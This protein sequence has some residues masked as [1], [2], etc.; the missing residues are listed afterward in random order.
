MA[1][2]LGGMPVKQQDATICASTAKLLDRGTVRACFVLAKSKGWAECGN[3]TWHF[4]EH[5]GWP[6]Q[7]VSGAQ[8]PNNLPRVRLYADVPMQLAPHNGLRLWSKPRPRVI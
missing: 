6:K 5:H 3:L 2:R 8:P 1:S 7:V 4:F